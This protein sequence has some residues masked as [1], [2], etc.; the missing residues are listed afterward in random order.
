MRNEVKKVADFWLAAGVDGFRL[1]VAQDI[2]DGDD[3][4]TVAWWQ[5]FDTHVRLMKADAF[6]VGEVNYDSLDGNTKIAPS[7]RG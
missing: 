5:E 1:D 7:S 4:Y 3:D 2:G 6:V